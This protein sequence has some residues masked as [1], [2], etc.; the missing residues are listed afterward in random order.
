MK[1]SWLSVVAGGETGGC[2]GIIVLLITTLLKTKQQNNV[3]FL[4]KDHNQRI[5]DRTRDDFKSQS[6]TKQKEMK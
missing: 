4:N 5:E 1:E 2:G 3:S 6:A